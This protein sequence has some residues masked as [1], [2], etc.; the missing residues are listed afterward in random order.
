MF[1]FI[2]PFFEENSRPGA[3]HTAASLIG[4]G[5]TILMLIAQKQ[6]MGVKKTR[7]TAGLNENFLFW[8]CI[9]CFFLGITSIFGIIG[10]CQEAGKLYKWIIIDGLLI[11]MNGF[12][13]YSNFF[14]YKIK[15]ENM[16]AAKKAGMSEGEHYEKVIAPSLLQQS[17]T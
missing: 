12:L 13:F 15:L 10:P 11:L 8:Q 6:L 7:N 5:G 1:S 14:T 3:D 17:K 16:A 9:T 4:L 2:L